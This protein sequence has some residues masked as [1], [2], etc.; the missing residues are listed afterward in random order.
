MK[1]DANT[2]ESLKNRRD[3]LAK[4]VAKLKATAAH[5]YLQHVT[6]LYHPDEYNAAVTALAS[7][8]SELTMVNSFLRG[9]ED[10]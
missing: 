3:L 4:E 2:I 10:V 8:Q 9:E 6:G 1:L 7:R 5:L